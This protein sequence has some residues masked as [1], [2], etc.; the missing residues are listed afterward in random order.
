M[1]AQPRPMTV[2]D[3]LAWEGDEDTAG[4]ELVDGVPVAMAPER[5][6]HT[7][8]KTAVIVALHRAIAETGRDCEVLADGATVRIAEDTAYRPDALV[9]CGPPAEDDATE[10]V[11]PI[12]VVEIVSPASVTRD[13]H[14]KLDGYFRVAS[15]Q[16][17]IVVI[18]QGRRVVHYRRRPGDEPDA[19]V[20][21][22]G[23]L[24]LDPRG[25]AAPVESLFPPAR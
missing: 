15:V 21:H 3:F 4:Y 2:D 16:H 22:D 17:Y 8:I 10:T 13:T 14:A 24:S 11:D 9:R 5:V 20:L 18:P 19:T 1:T 23:M 12:V 7:R 6:I 25:L